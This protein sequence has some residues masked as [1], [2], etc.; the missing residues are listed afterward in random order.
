MNTFQ[1][2]IVKLI[3]IF[4]VILIQQEINKRSVEP[5]HLDAKGHIWVTHYKDLI[6]LRNIIIKSESYIFVD[7]YLCWGIYWY[8]DDFSIYESSPFIV[9]LPYDGTNKSISPFRVKNKL[10]PNPFN[11]LLG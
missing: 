4:T 7:S 9:L 6:I 11:L 8:I 3:V 2:V 10:H 1:A 5:S